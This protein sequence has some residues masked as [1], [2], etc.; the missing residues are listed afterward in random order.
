MAARAAISS[1]RRTAVETADPGRLVLMA[2]EGAIQALSE[3]LG[4][5]EAKDYETK[6]R[7]LIRAQDFV[8]ELLAGL[9]PEAGQVAANLRALY[10]YM[11]G[12]LGLVNPATEGERLAEVHGMLVELHAAWQAIIEG[13]RLREVPRRQ[14]GEVTP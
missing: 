3:A 5:L 10:V 12:R 13:P 8:S 4:A 1:Y 7:R 11:L 2:Y 6:G 14:G 9:D